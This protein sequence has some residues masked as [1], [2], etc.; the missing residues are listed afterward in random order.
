VEVL[1]SLVLFS[2]VDSGFDEVN[3]HSETGFLGA[4][5]NF[6]DSNLGVLNEVLNESNP[7]LSLAAMFASMGS[8]AMRSSGTIA[9][10]HA[11]VLSTFLHVLV[12]AVGVV[13]GVSVVDESIHL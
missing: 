7:L 4:F 6:F 1:G 5:V 12:V 13:F 2:L 10:A 11:V 3:G 9:T 8:M